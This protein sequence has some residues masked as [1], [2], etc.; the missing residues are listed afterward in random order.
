MRRHHKDL[1]PIA[2]INLTSLLDVTFVLLIAFMIVAPALKYGIDLDLPTVQEGA[3]QLTQNQIQLFSIVIPKPSQ[4]EQQFFL[5][6]DP[7]TLRDIEVRL[8]LQRESGRMPSVEIQADREVPY[9]TFIQV[10][11]ALRRAGIEAVGLPV[12][13][14]Q[15][16]A[17][18][19]RAGGSLTSS[20]PIERSESK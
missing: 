2:Q 9:D 16:T 17:P 19:K 18:T 10:V 7:V 6:D 3:P 15:V 5:N 8:R 14:G 13:T 4:G 11:A 20:E 1:A 12:E